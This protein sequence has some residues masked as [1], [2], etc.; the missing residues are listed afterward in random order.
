MENYVSHLERNGNRKNTIQTYIKGIK[1][2]INWYEKTHGPFKSINI[3]IMDIKEYKEYLIHD[4][5]YKVS[6]INN[7]LECIKN[8]F[9]YLVEIG[10]LKENPSIYVSNQK[11]ANERTVKWIE[12][13][14]KNRLLRYLEDPRLMEKNP[15]KA[16]RNLAI[17]LFML[18]AGLRISEVRALTIHDIEDG[19]V[20][21]RDGK[22]GKARKVP[23]NS[24]LFKAYSNW[25]I[26]RNLKDVE[27]QEL[28]ISQKKNPITDNGIQEL[29]KSIRKETGLTLTP[30]SLR[31]TFCHDLL[32][33]GISINY[34][35]EL[36]GHSDIDSTRIYVTPSE[37]EKK[38]FVE[39]L[40]SGKYE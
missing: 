7:K 1:F 38:E 2:F 3:T 23:M 22:G 35:A 13:Q 14:E 21:I 16:S 18:M 29:F 27:H 36:A 32:Q 11:D 15:W 28:F 8:Y 5:K 4:A 39:K 30:H 33:K 9:K 12:R 40:A 19:F 26:Y 10:E 6:T 17:V 31:H 25:L 34:V 20:L 37:T 24:D